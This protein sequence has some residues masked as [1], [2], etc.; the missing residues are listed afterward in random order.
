VKRFILF[1]VC[2]LAISTVTAQWSDEW[3]NSSR[4]KHLLYTNGDLM[5]G[6]SSGGNLG[7]SF[8]YNSRYSVEV[9][10]SATSNQFNTPI[11]GLKSAGKS[12]TTDAI[13]PNQMMENFN[14][15][16]G[17]HFN[18]NSKETIRFVLQGGPGMS[19]MMEWIDRQPVNNSKSF[20][21]SGLVKTKDISLMVN[22]KFEFPVTDLLGF[23]AGPTLIMNHDKR[24]LTFNIGFMYGIITKN[25]SRY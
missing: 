14:I 3:L 19:V 13:S 20:V 7:M 12:N 6:N 25:Q 5:V 11:P 17:R 1:S 9:G 18:M 24:F 15:M 10:Y 23:S 2:V 22:S 4:N 8:V 21:I 16:A